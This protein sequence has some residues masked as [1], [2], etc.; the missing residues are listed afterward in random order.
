MHVLLF[1]DF[2][3]AV[4]TAD[5]TLSGTLNE[6]VVGKTSGS[7]VFYIDSDIRTSGSQLTMQTIVEIKLGTTT[8]NSNIL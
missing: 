1:P 6:L 7:S 8:T 5:I 4:S 2:S 3:E